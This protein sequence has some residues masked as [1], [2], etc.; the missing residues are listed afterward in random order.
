MNLSSCCD[1]HLSLQKEFEN[2]KEYCL[3]EYD[4]QKFLILTRD[5]VKKI[6]SENK[7]LNSVLNTYLNIYCKN[8]VETDRNY[9]HEM[10]TEEILKL[11]N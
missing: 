3:L 9:F 7:N 8:N 5:E 10:F 6:V 4:S 1:L 2:V 11:K